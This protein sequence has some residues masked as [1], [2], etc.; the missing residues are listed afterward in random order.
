MAPPLLALLMSLAPPA[1][2]PSPAFAPLNLPLPTLGGAQFWGD[3][4]H[5]GGW[6]MQ[7]H[8]LTGH[9]RLLDDWDVRRAWGDRS[10]CDAALDAAA[11]THGLPRPRG[12]T[13]VLVHGMIRTGKCFAKL[14]GE[15]REAGFETV[16]VD[17][18]STRQSLR[19]S[20]AM[21]GE[22]TDG[23]LREQDPADP[24]TLHFVCHSAGGLIVRAW[25]EAN[26][27]A[28]VGRTVLMGVPNGGAAMADRVRGLPLIGGSLDLLW[29]SAA[30]EL[31]T[32]EG[33][34]LSGLPAPRGEF[35]TIAGCRGAEGGYNPLI[36]GDDDGTVAVREARLTGEADHLAVR[37][38]GHSFLMTNPAVRAATV[39][40]L[41]GGRLTTE[42]RDRQGAR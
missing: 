1:E 39:R 35:A 12:E 27:D 17:Y 33:E 29:G 13:V 22:V 37:G 9:H 28:P 11:E 3:V 5:R 24:V 4:R 40:F 19:A 18:P 10:V 26:A 6:R 15:L 31:S 2:A 23:L 7:R 32:T 14:A 42:S 8:V 38:A 20:A 25:G 21:L 30:G 41:T 34:T 16:S 36:P